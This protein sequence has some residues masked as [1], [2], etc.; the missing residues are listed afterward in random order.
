MKNKGTL[1][2]AA[3][4]PGIPGIRASAGKMTAPAHIGVA[5]MCDIQR[6]MPEYRLPQFS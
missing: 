2:S 4:C 1:S 6:K 3:F 5:L